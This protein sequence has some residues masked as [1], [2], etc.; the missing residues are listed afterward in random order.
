MY[1][2]CSY[3]VCQKKLSENEEKVEEFKKSWLRRSGERFQCYYRINNHYS[4]IENKKN[5]KQQVIHSMLWPSI[6]I[7]ICGA[8]FLKLETARRNMTCCGVQD[9][10]LTNNDKAKQQTCS[11][12]LHLDGTIQCDCKSSLLQ[13]KQQRPSLTPQTGNCHHSLEQLTQSPAGEDYHSTTSCSKSLSCL[14]RVGTQPSRDNSQAVNKANKDLLH[15]TQPL[16]ASLSET[17]IIN[18]KLTSQRSDD[19]GQSL[20]PQITI[21]TGSLTDSL[22]SHH[23]TPV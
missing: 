1:F 19:E 14:E 9:K 18:H 21:T 7:L 22:S 6:V 3:T 12:R 8:I 5:S 13:K 15:S 16:Q 4:L 11:N 17:G 23:E 2:Q 20:I 10:Y